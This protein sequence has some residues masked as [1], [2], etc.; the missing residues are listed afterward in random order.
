MR[1]QHR[2]SLFALIATLVALTGFVSTLSSGQSGRKRLHHVVRVGHRNRKPSRVVAPH[3]QSA[4]AP[5]ARS[6]VSACSSALCRLLPI[7]TLLQKGGSTLD[8]QNFVG[9]T[10]HDLPSDGGLAVLPNTNTIRWR[11]NDPTFGPIDTGY[12]TPTTWNYT[13]KPAE[14]VFVTTSAGITICGDINFAPTNSGYVD[15]VEGSVRVH[16][17]VN[18]IQPASIQ[19][20]RAGTHFGRPVTQAVKQ[21]GDPT[22]FLVLTNNNFDRN[23]PN[24]ERDDENGTALIPAP[25]TSAAYVVRKRT[26]GVRLPLS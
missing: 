22:K 21:S 24:G 1:I 10:P 2:S 7:L 18:A 5:I 20:Y 17:V 8:C 16:Y 25:G 11:S 9:N 15:L 6:A 13:A 23:N 19:P 3:A 14:L 4:R 12:V 26:T